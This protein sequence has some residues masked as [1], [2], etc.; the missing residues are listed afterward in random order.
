MSKLYVNTLYPQ[1]G[2]TVVLS[3][4]LDVSGTLK[5]YQFETITYA[6]T[7]YLGDTVFGN[8]RTDHHTFN[9]NVSG[10]GYAIFVGG[11][12][13]AGNVQTSGSLYALHNVSG[14]GKGLFVGGI[15]TAG[16]LKVSGSVTFSGTTTGTDISGSGKGF[17]VGGVEAQGDIQ[18]SG[19]LYA[20]HNVSGSGK[21]L[22]VG[23]IETAGD[24]SISGS[25]SS[26]AAITLDATTDINLDAD[27][28]EVFFKDAGAQQG[29]LKMD[30]ANSFIL[31]SS[32]STNDLY[33]KS[34]RDI[35]LDA[36]GGELFFKDGGVQQGVLKMD[37]A[38]SFILSSSISTNDLYL[39]SGR[40]IVLDADGANVTLKDGGT[41]YLDI[42]QSSGDCI[43]SSS[44]DTKDLIFHGDDATEVFR[45]DGSAKSLLMASSKKIEFADTGEYIYSDGTD[46]RLDAGGDISIETVTT[47]LEWGNNSGEHIVGDGSSGLTVAS[48]VAI[49]L[50]A[51]TDINLDAD[52]G[53]V[54]FKDAG[55]QQGVLKMDT[56]NSFILSSSISTNDLYLKSGRDIILD[57]SGSDV[58]PPSD[59]TINLGSSTRRWANVYTADLHL[60]N[61]RGDWTI[62][63]EENYIC[64]VNNK[65]GKRYKMVV[66]EI[67]D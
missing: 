34:G 62:V 57:P 14:S 45:V 23:G 9:G 16:D 26:G 33:L 36:D 37:T 6:A 8:N 7:T 15:E 19:S 63:E 50:D 51:T 1:S 30:T 47:K 54:F 18:T 46:L 40:D 49:T 17:F 20:R 52:G 60:K 13:A 58:L 22:F 38:N 5:A 11:V 66:E 65:T 24:L 56:A 42:I 3:G 41:A 21:G 25:V 44:V 55:V 4:N 61:D 39:K 28:G 32:I 67:K 31:S 53:E 29:V 59:N 48:G 10:S 64:V 12:E 35:V 2:T 27:G 43:F